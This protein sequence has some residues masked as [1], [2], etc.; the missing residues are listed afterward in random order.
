MVLS[1]ACSSSGSSAPG[2]A[3][4]PSRPSIAR[5]PALNSDAP[6]VTLPLD[7]YVATPQ[8]RATVNL[9]YFYGLQACLKRFGFSYAIPPQYVD[10]SASRNRFTLASLKQAEKYG[11]TGGGGTAGSS[12]NG[13]AA[14]SKAEGAIITGTSKASG[15][16]DGGCAAE[17][18][19][20]LED[21]IPNGQVYSDTWL[22]QTLSFQTLQQ[23]MSDPRVLAANAAWSSCMKQ[24]GYQYANPHE[25]QN[26]KRW[27][28]DVSD[29]NGA[30]HP[31]ALNIATAVASV[32]CTRAVK[33]IEIDATVDTELQ[34]KIIEKNA[35]R[36]QADLDKLKMVLEKAAAVVAA[37]P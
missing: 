14:I 17:S 34:K 21:W 6:S 2:S 5:G 9:A 28:A 20:Q 37:H 30:V 15:V 35:T 33:L 10:E 29:E 22:A 7:A 13:D 26:D 32:K 23:T 3:G 1:G 12:D 16:P 11:F 19:R 25:A 36:L 18:Y 24:Q 8:Q 27:R 31:S 4:T